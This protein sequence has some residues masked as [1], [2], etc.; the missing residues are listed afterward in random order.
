ME[1]R[2][3]IFEEGRE[4]VEWVKRSGAKLVSVIL[5]GSAVRGWGEPEDLDVLIVVDEPDTEVD[6]L[7]RS[8]CGMDLAL[9][10]KFGLHPE[11][12]IL[13]KVSIGKGNPLFYYSIIRDGV[14]LI[15]NKDLFLDALIK[16]EGRKELERACGLERAYGLLRHAEKDLEAAKDVTDLQLAAEGAYRACVEAIYALLRKHGMPIPSNHKE[17]REMLHTL[18]EIYPEANISSRYS[19][20][21]EH[22]HAECFYHGECGRI[23]EWVSEAKEFV[24]KIATLI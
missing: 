4:I 2:G 16:S 22:L 21:F 13:K 8:F 10:K 11:L 12:T 7:C 6:K 19:T 14:V 5:F 9:S 24:H 20:L 1:T 18:D 23:R 17:E 15:G 3:R